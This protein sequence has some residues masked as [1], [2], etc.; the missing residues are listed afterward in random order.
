ME[1]R[2][3][4]AIVRAARWSALSPF[5]HPDGCGR[6]HEVS[7]SA[8][9][10]GAVQVDDFQLVPLLKALQMPRVTA[11]GLI[12]KLS[13]GHAAAHWH[14]CCQTS[15]SMP[16]GNSIRGWQVFPSVGVARR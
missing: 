11:C 15:L 3:F 13:L 6:S 7:V 1:P 8:P 2:E 5:L 12:P 16:I 9:F 14:R 10:F 4:D